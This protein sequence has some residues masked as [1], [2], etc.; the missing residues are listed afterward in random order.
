LVRDSE[1]VPSSGWALEIFLNK[2]LPMKY[3]LLL[4]F[5]CLFTS[6]PLIGQQPDFQSAPTSEH[7]VLILLSEVWADVNELAAEVAK[8]NA[9][10]YTDQGLKVT[11]LLMPYL[12]NVPVL[13]VRTFPDKKSAMAYYHRL[14][15]EKPNFMQMKMVDAVWPLTTK[16][17]NQIIIHESL[18]EYPQF[19]ET[20]YMR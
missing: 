1:P 10:E 18:G 6:L 2:R 13:Y 8:Y 14:Y 12:S 7:C 19:F 5:F 16:N 17:Y 20:N 11:R 3:G 9:E 15:E 4:T